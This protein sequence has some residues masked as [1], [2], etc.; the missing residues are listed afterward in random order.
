VTGSSQQKIPVLANCRQTQVMLVC[1]AATLCA[2]TVA[3]LTNSRIIALAAAGAFAAVI[4][5]AGYRATAAHVVSSPQDANSRVP[6]TSLNVL[7][8]TT[9]L[10]AI[11]CAWA[12]AALL[13]AYPIAGLQWRHGWEYGSALG[14]A[15]AGFALYR[16][17]LSQNF[18]ASAALAA[19]SRAAALA[20]LQ[21]VAIAVTIAWILASGKLHTLKNDWLA[22]DVFLATGCAMLALSAF[23]VTRV[24]ADQS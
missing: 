5:V 22:N 7:R 16:R 6:M 9:C 1:G 19:V 11:T 3:A 24:R 2:I 8:T 14:L 12:A 18:D 4:I 17:W 21:G 15:A 20:T 13:L 10:S 23:L